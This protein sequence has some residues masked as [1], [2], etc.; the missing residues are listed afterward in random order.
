M[1]VFGAVLNIQVAAGGSSTPVVGGRRPRMRTAE[2]WLRPLRPSD[3][4]SAA[5]RL[6]LAPGALSGASM[7]QI[8]ARTAPRGSATLGA[9][10]CGLLTSGARVPGGPTRAGL[11]LGR[12]HEHRLRDG[13]VDIAR[14]SLSED[15]PASHVR[16]RSITL[17][18]G[19]KTQQCRHRVDASHLALWRGEERGGGKADCVWMPDRG[20]VQRLDRHVAHDVMSSNKAATHSHHV[21]PRRHRLDSPHLALW[22]WGAERGARCRLE[23]PCVAVVQRCDVASSPGP[24]G[25]PS[26]SRRSAVAV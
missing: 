26:G 23:P 8:V 3:R 21:R 25:W 10:G 17:D 7:R 4:A 6:R 11:G 1:S 12:R 22:W 9:H 20:W 5:R 18:H 14:S 2:P 24:G 13:R 16:L 15:R 19:R